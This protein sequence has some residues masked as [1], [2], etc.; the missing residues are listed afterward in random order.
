MNESKKQ[1]FNGI[2]II[3]G[4]GLL[5]YSLTV[6]G[7]SIYTQIVGLMVLMIGAYRASA[8]WAKHKDDHLDE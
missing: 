6:T 2:L 4:G 1:L 5:V 8:H 3:I 7:T